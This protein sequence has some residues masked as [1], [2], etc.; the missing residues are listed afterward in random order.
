MQLS[1]PSHMIWL[2]QKQGELESGN[3]HVAPM[4][5]YTTFFNLV[6]RTRLQ[7]ISACSIKALAVINSWQ[8]EQLAD[9]TVGR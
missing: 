1:N 3:M 8:V 6:G 7:H 9:E 5:G 2:F 4:E